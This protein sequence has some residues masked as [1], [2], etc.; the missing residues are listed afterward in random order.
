MYE[1]LKPF[2]D[3]EIKIDGAFLIIPLKLTKLL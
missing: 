3:L 2:L 1:R